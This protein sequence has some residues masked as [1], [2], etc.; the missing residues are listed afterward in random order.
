MSWPQY[1]DAADQKEQVRRELEKRRKRGETYTRFEAPSGSKL[2]QTFWGQA[3]CRHL[4]TYG[5]YESRLPRGRSY[6]RAGNVYNLTVHEGI[7]AAEVTGSSLYEVEIRIA[8]LE[9]AAWNA[10]KSQCAGQVGSL[11]DLLAGK[12]GG[13]VMKVV[14][15]PDAGLFP[16]RSE[17]R[18]SCS[19]PDFADLC[20]H[21]AAVLYA[22][23]VQ[24]DRDPNIFFELRGAD[25][26]ELIAASTEALTDSVSPS[27]GGLEGED[28]SALFGIDLAETEEN[29]PSPPEP[30][31]KKPPANRAILV[32]AP[33][34][35][36]K[37][38]AA[39]KNRPPQP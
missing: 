7:I 39:K 37:N 21:Q 34:G 28:L 9:K 35:A 25:P 22:I 30:S 33:S 5:G 18:H 20:K 16:N 10:I 11:L 8:P 3:W 23:G 27:G 13:G 14:T 32:K 17:I 1:G 12:L 6:L 2:A 26:S 36:H 38:S 19:C 31:L 24:F 4:E 29:L 15:D